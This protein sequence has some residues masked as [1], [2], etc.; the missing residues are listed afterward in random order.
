MFRLALLITVCVTMPLVCSCA[1]RET[2][3][4]E[5]FQILEQD[6]DVLWATREITVPAYGTG[7][8]DGKG[9]KTMVMQSVTGLFA[10]YRPPADTPDKPTCY[11]ARVVWDPTDMSWPGHVRM[12]DGILSVPAAPEHPSEPVP[13]PRAAKPRP[14][15]TD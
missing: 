10:C 13:E 9:R 1:K 7:A 2:A 3:R 4:A 11:L 14:V 15:F 5:G 12:V 6:S 8:V